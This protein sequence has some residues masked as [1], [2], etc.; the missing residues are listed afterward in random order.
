[1]PNILQSQKLCPSYRHISLFRCLIVNISL[2]LATHRKHSWPI[3]SLR[4]ITAVLNMGRSAG[5]RSYFYFQ[6]VLYHISV[7]SYYIVIVSHN[8]RHLKFLFS[9]SANSTNLSVS[10]VNWTLLCSQ[11]SSAGWWILRD[12]SGHTL[13]YQFCFSLRLSLKKNKRKEEERRRSRSEQ[14]LRKKRIPDPA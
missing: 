14:D 12:C 5:H 1:M 10:P 3:C 8:F 6:I 2:S 4:V 7:V 11:F 9:K 13:F